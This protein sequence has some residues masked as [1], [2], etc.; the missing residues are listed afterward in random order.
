MR[1]T[2]ETIYGY[3]ND[4]PI[5]DFEVF[6]NWLSVVNY[7]FYT[8]SPRLSTVGRLEFFDDFQGSRT[9]FEGLYCACAWDM[10]FRPCQSVQ[11]RTELRVDHNVESR[12][13]EGQ[14]TLGTAGCDLI[15]RW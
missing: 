5:G 13:F 7:L 10:V 12:P 15:L 6:A 14:N 4:V 9:G 8:I 11:F 3:Q 1:Y 2:F